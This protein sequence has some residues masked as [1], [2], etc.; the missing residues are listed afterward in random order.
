MKE[1]SLQPRSNDM[2]KP[3]FYRQPPSSQ[4]QS[5]EEK[6]SV[7][8]QCRNGAIPCLSNFRDL[9]KTYPVWWG[10]EQKPLLQCSTRFLKGKG[11][12]EGW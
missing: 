6:F 8:L 5:P 9:L 7:P 10:G 2:T 4:L 3:P 1:G 11:V 12:E